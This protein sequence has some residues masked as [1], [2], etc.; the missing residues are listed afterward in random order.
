MKFRTEVG[1]AWN[2]IPLPL[3]DEPNEGGAGGGGG[4]GTGGDPNGNGDGK[5]GGD[6]SF[7][8]DAGKAYAELDADTRTWLQKAGV[9][10]DP[11]ALA[12]KAYNQEKLLGGSIRLP[13]KDAT[14]EELTEFFGKL[15]RPAEADK[16]ELKAPTDLPEGIPY[17]GE[18]AK[19]FRT[20]AH[21]AGLSQTQAAALHD[22]YVGMAGSAYTA[23]AAAAQEA[24]QGRATKA[25]EELVKLWGPL[26]GDTAS[27][28]FEI[29]DKVFTQAPGGQEFLTELKELGLVGPNKEILSAPLAKMLASLG[30]AL[31]TED[32]V[33]RGNPDVVGNP[34]DEK[35]EQFNVTEQMRL[36]KRDPD[37]ARS[38]IAAAGK[39]PLD[40]GLTA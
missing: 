29:A 23:Q 12:T 3:F 38:L 30:T 10:A 11:K 8:F 33:L 16:Y 15:G 4:E 14:P 18:V 13:G 9:D 6:G 22:W 25:A 26:E 37:Q 31:Y 36:V 28:N 24:L 21:A 17:D 19:G 34:F 39:K 40:F 2:A 5:E 20:A 35:S 32:G 27:A 1:T 7:V